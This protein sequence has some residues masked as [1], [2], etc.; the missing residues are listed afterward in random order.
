MS[1]NKNKFG[2]NINYMSAYEET[3]LEKEIRKQSE[4]KNPYS[5]E[6]TNK[7][8]WSEGFRKGAKIKVEDFKGS[9]ILMSQKA[10]AMVKM[11]EEMKMTKAARMLRNNL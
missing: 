6:C 3:P 11:F 7:H 8:L 9:E 1:R 4:E 2:P 5:D 10:W